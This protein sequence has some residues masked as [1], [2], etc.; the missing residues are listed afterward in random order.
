MPVPQLLVAFA[1]N[2]MVALLNAYGV[3][4]AVGGPPWFGTFHNAS[5]Y[6]VIT[7]GISP[8]LVGA[9]RRLRA[10]PGRR[11]AAGLLDLLVAL[12]SRQRAAEP[13][14]RP[15]VPDLVRRRRQVVALDR[16]APPDRA[17]GARA[18]RSPCICII[19]AEVAGKLAAEQLSR[20]GAACAAAAGAVGGGALRR[21]GRERRHPDRDGGPD[22]A[23]L[24]RPE[25]VSR[26]R[27][28]NEA[29]SRC[30]CS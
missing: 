21:E 17:G 19:A 11:S 30:S 16:V 22:L 10:D 23:D 3:R 4:R 7:A 6:I 13:H 1:T 28:P 27:R 14:A 18:G 24:A 2:C 20:R 25:P 9:G 15:G 8:A 26:R 5:L 29:C 12:V